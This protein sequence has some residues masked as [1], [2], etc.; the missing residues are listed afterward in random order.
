[1]YYI[2][3]ILYNALWAPLQGTDITSKVSIDKQT[4]Q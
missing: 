2:L 4:C 1:M 3:G